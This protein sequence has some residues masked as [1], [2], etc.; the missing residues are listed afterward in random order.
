VA[1]P[2]VWLPPADEAL[3][4]HEQALPMA[5][6]GGPETE[7]DVLRPTKGGSR[8][9]VQAKLPDGSLGLFLV[10]T[11]ADVSV[12]T[13]ATADRLGLDA[14]REVDVW[15]LSGQASVHAVLLPELTLGDVTVPDI[16][17]LVG[18]PGFQ[19]TVGFMPV[20]GLLGNNV[21]HRFTL[22]I[23]YPAN[24]MVLHPP[25]TPVPKHRSAPM[26]YDGA[27]ITTLVTVAT[28]GEHPEQHDVVAQVDTGASELTLCAAT[29]LPFADDYTQGLE[30]VRGIGASETLPPYRF[31][32]M[33]RRIPV[34]HVVLGGAQ[35]DVDLPARWV[36][37]ENT[38]TATCGTG[39]MRALIGHE[40]LEGHRVLFDYADGRIALL[41]SKRKPRQLDGNA[42]LL[43]QE[44][45]AHGQ[46]ADRGLVRAKLLLGMGEDDR[47]LGELQTYVADAKDAADHVE[48]QVLLA[49][50]LRSM[51]RH[52]EAWAALDGLSAGDLVDQD[53]IVGTVN[54][55][56]F[57]G[58]TDDARDLA[59]RAVAE[60]SDDGW[61]HVALADVLLADR[62]YQDAQ[63]ELLEAARI[64]QYPDAHLLRRAR[65]ALASGDRY[66]A[67]AHIRELL[68][69]YPGGGPYLWFYAMLVQGDAERATFKADVDDAM[70][71]LHPDTRPFDFL[72]AADRVMGDTTDLEAEL[73]TGLQGQCDPLPDGDPEKDNCY[74]WY[75]ALAGE[76]LDDALVRIRRA[77]EKTGDRADFLDTEAMVHLAR[78]EYEEAA[79]SANSAAR[80]SPDDVYMLWQAERVSEI[81]TEQ[82]ANTPQ[83]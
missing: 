80:L 70:A 83:P 69:L 1:L 55:L 21:W 64:E 53:Q 36:G 52:E 45:A 47:A 26:L 40:Y 81:A 25:G 32:E 75:Y 56:L 49:R 62:R 13:Q 37:Y 24:L 12:L 9:F 65:V 78:H 10:D 66:G 61:A 82:A 54:G 17:V 14:N 7:L 74:A 44:V 76:K 33:T 23:D 11:G 59:Q 28:G 72:V 6:S 60:R 79:K 39:Q 2:A 38:R 41:K 20:D 35:V 77:L 19:D 4:G 73:Q 42:V 63:D 29:G 3:F 15:G 67:M 16:D 48:A 5:Y 50:V 57:D 34:D 22:E 46:A 8:I 51:G 43:D 31:L 68:A 27:H 30:T 58:R 71:R 18:V